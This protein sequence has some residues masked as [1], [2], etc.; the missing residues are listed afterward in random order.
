M[1][2]KDPGELVGVTSVIEKMVVS[3]MRERER[4]KE[5]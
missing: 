3:Q 5:N 4:I 1:R 2:K